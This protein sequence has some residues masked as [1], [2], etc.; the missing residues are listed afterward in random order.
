[1]SRVATMASVAQNRDAIGDRLHL[2]QA[3]GDVEDGD[4][5]GA[6][7]AD[8]LEQAL[9]LDGRENGR[10]LVEGD[11]LMRHQQGAGDLHELPVGDGEA[12]TCRSGSMPVPSSA[13]TARA[14]SRMV[15][16]STKPKRRISRPRKRF[17]ATVRSGASRI[18]WWTSTMPWRSASTG[19]ENVTGWPSR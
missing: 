8:D 9:G 19:P 18:S 10:R 6:Q 17:C 1:M 16:S 3:V 15:A 5:L 11:D 2:V 13:R 12:A 14:R 7:L 4:A